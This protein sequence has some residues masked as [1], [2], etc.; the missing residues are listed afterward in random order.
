M[1]ELNKNGVLEI[2]PDDY[3]NLAFHV[4]FKVSDPAK[5]NRFLSDLWTSGA[6]NTTGISVVGIGFDRTKNQ[7]QKG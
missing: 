1:E 5:A 2:V 4:N 7:I 6:E 3:E